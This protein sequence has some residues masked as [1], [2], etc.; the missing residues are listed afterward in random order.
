MCVCCIHDLF[1]R[2]IKGLS[3]DS[4]VRASLVMN[5]LRTAE[6]RAGITQNRGTKGLVF[7]S[8]KGSQDASSELRMHLQN[9]GYRQ[10][11]SG[12]GSCQN[13][14]LRNAPM[15]SFWDSLKVEETHGRGFE[16]REAARRCVF[17]YNEG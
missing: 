5:A 6:F 2:E 17:A 10:S 8:D 7:Y 9:Y 3:V 13:T 11:T 1:A 14:Q 12:T 4:H 15:E 16:T